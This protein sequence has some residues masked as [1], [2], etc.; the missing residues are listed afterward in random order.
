MY[1]YYPPHY[2]PEQH[3]KKNRYFGVFAALAITAMFIAGYVVGGIYS[4]ST[5]SPTVQSL[6]N[7]LNTLQ[8]QVSRSTTQQVKTVIVDNTSLAQIYENAK[9]AIVVISGVVEQQSFFGTSYGSVQGSGFVYSQDGETVIVTN[10]HVVQDASNIT[11]TFAD[12]DAYPAA[13]RGADAYADLAVL[14]VQ[15]STE[16]VV[17]LE[18]ASSSLLQVGDPV[19]AIGSPFGLSGTMTTG[20]ISQLGRTLQDETAGSYP[21]ANII[22]TSVP[23]NPGNSGGPL[24]NYQGQVIGITTAIVQNSNGLGFAIPAN[25]LLREIPTI[26]ETGS[27]PDHAYLGVS[28]TDMTYALAHAMGI[29][30]TYGW[31]ITQVSA[32]GAAAKAGLKGGDQRILVNGE[33][34]IIGGDIIIGV[35]GT[36]IIDGD[37]F[38][39]YLEEHTTPNQTISLTIIRDA[40]QKTLLVTL[41]QRPVL[42]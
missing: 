5:T 19:I 24:L 9:D 26:V 32:A 38:M 37:A 36:R 7:Q 17:P 13:V 23:I 42:Q 6:Q 31:L 35:D 8:Q 15:G 29:S 39:S 2:Q 10:E 21:I 33:T 3:H 30:T 4:T 40:Q 18:I 41:G 28:G 25:T 1:E 34:Q 27:Y 11:V 16:D 14:T 22:Q 12:G 20:I